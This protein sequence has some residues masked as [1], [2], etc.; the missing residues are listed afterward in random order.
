[1]RKI[2]KISLLSILIPLN[3]S[4]LA[5]CGK[6]DINEK[7]TSIDQDKLEDLYTNN[8]VKGNKVDEISFDIVYNGEIENITITKNDTFNDVYNKFFTHYKDTICPNATNSVINPLYTKMKYNYSTY[9]ENYPTSN[10]IDYIGDYS[11]EV[12]SNTAI[13]ISN[14]G[15]TFSNGNLI[16]KTIDKATS[17][18]GDINL[19]EN[20]EAKDRGNYNFYGIDDGNYLFE[21]ATTYPLGYSTFLDQVSDYEWKYLMPDDDNKAFYLNISSND[22]IDLYSKMKKEYTS[23]SLKYRPEYLHYRTEIQ[24]L[25]EREDNYISRDFLI[26]NFINPNYYYNDIYEKYGVFKG[27]IELTS[28]YLIIKQKSNYDA[29]NYLYRDYEDGLIDYDEL[30]SLLNNIS[31]RTNIKNSYTEEEI[32][33]DYNDINIYDYSDGITTYKHDDLGFSYYKKTINFKYERNFTWKQDKKYREFSNS[34]ITDPFSELIGKNAKY[35]INKNYTYEMYPIDITREEIDNKLL[36][37]KNYCK[38]NNIL[39]KYDFI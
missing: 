26:F 27:S 31:I 36:D 39:D 10:R 18:E 13:Y 8:L 4:L 33:I 25:A 11:Y 7:T 9:K 1:M 5:S 19:E 38:N 35:K 24:T 17:N 3:I 22:N 29:I 16:T 30:T 23:G 20:L 21:Y 34:Y 28:N 14:G 6:G 32:W 37:F 12:D 15:G 2:F